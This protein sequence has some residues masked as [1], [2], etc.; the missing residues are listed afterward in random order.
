[1]TDMEFRVLI[2]AM[3]NRFSIGGVCEI[4]GVNV[5]TV[6]RWSRGENLPYPTIRH[7]LREAFND[8]NL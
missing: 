4:L 1:M 6:Q 7:Y 8:P 2:Q 5:L 3:S